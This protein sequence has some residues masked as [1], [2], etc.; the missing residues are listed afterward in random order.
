[1]SSYLSIRIIKNKD[2]EQFLT[3]YKELEELEIDFSDD[4]WAEA[5]K[6]IND[7]SFLLTWSSRS[8]KLYRVFDDEI[9]YTY[10]STIIKREDLLSII[11][12]LN[13]EYNHYND[14]I[15]FYKKYG[16]FKTDI[17]SIRINDAI[18]YLDLIKPL[19]NEEKIEDIKTIILNCENDVN[20][21]SDVEEYEEELDDIR[22]A[23]TFVEGLLIIYDYKDDDTFLIYDMD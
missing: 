3:K 9:G 4:K 23:K 21:F 11:E 16:F 15:S 19:A 6:I 20:C 17:N 5:Y 7:N 13:K 8:F 2:F 1:M 18:N 10:K 22:H 12:N 14:I